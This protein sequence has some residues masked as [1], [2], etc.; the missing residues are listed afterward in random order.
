MEGEQQQQQHLAE[1]EEAQK[2][3]E[4]QQDE[5]QSAEYIESDELQRK[6]LPRVY[7]LEKTKQ[8]V[9][10]SKNPDIE[11]YDYLLYD[12]LKGTNVLWTKAVIIMYPLSQLRPFTPA[13]GDMHY[14]VVEGIG[15][16]AVEL[17]RKI[18]RKGDIFLVEQGI[19]HNIINNED[20]SKLVLEVD[21]PGHIDFR[22][23]YKPMEQKKKEAEESQQELFKGYYKQKQQQGRE[24]QKPAERTQFA[25]KFL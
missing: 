5:K 21:Y 2:G 24:E 17:L 7:N 12:A 4:Q 14:K 16:V 19:K 18:V 25:D 13:S 9:I 1:K 20:A 10:K 3:Q 8:L 11:I 23:I 15:E 6:R 22:D